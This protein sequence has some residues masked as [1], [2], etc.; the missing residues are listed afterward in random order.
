MRVRRERAIELRLEVFN[1]LNTS[2]EGLASPV[3]TVD[4]SKRDAQPKLHLARILRAEDAAEVR[5]PENSVRK[6]K[7]ARLKR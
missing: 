4:R 1:L 3:N 7:F 2:R 6:S 5:R